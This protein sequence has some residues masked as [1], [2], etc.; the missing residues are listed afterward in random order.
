MR[1]YNLYAK[2]PKKNRK[3]IN[4][5]SSSNL[6]KR[7][8][9]SKPNQVWNTDT[10][11]IPYLRGHLFLATIIDS[12]TKK[13]LGFHIGDKLGTTNILKALSEATDNNCSAEYMHSDQGSEFQSLLYVT[14]CR[15]K[16]IKIS[17]SSRGSPWQNG[18]QE[19]FFGRMKVET[20][21][22]RERLN[23]EE[24]MNVICEYIDYYNN[25]RI[26]TTLKM[27]PQSFISKFDS[28]SNFS[29]T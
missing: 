29:G 3:Y 11:Y 25:R 17:M 15:D 8:K 7:I 10:S 5:V 1:K 26:H 14:A 20:K 13:I 28:L 27:S 12:Y 22:K 9:A 6:V 2:Y 16:G 18:L 21:I 19:S 23:K 4:V 24:T